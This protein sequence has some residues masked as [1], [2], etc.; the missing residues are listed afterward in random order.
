MAKE[1]L[2]KIVSAE[3]E[4]DSLIKT[5]KDEARL[6][7]ETAEKKS[8]SI[9]EDSYVKANIEVDKIKNEAKESMKDELNHIQELSEQRCEM[10]SNIDQAKFDEAK[11][12]LIERIVK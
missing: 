8:K 10:I 6:L 11:K 2:L 7:I 4:A 1:A 5:A 3:N 9:V 12:L